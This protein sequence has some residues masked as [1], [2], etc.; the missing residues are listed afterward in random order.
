MDIQYIQCTPTK[1]F[2]EQFVKKTFNF[3]DLEISNV[4]SKVLKKDYAH[5]APL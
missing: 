3:D 1:L 4:E 5:I 2:F